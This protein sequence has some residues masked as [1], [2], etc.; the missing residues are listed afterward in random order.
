M[1]NYSKYQHDTNNGAAI[2]AADFFNV[3]HHSVGSDNFTVQTK[4]KHFKK[5]FFLIRKMQ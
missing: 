2:V 4:S 3:S 5:R 1:L